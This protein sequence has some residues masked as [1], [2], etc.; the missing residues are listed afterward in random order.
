MIGSS[1]FGLLVLDF[2]PDFNAEP[3]NLLDPDV[4]PLQIQE[5]KN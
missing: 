5:E 1:S 4:P 3:F 2:W